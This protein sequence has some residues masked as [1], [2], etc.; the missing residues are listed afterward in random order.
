M[1]RSPK[2][3]VGGSALVSTA[4]NYA[5]SHLFVFQFC[6]KG[7][8]ALALPFSSYFVKLHEA[9]MLVENLTPK[10]VARYKPFMQ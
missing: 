1:T 5:R 8:P 10:K 4:L 3:V 6:E 2:W 9:A 7:G